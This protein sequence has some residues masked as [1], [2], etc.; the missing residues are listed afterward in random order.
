MDL[1]ITLIIIIITALVSLGGFSTPRIIDDLIFYPARMK[2]GRELHRYI[3]HGFI[4]ADLV[5]LFFNMFTFY[6]FGQ[7]IEFKFHE[8]TGHKYVFPIFYLTALIV[9]SIPDYLNHRNDYYYRSLGASGAVNAILFSFVLL[10]PW[11]II[12]VLVIPIP[13]FIY[14]VLFV[15]YSIYAERKGGDRV[16]HSAH[17]FGAAYGVAFTL[18]LRPEVFRDFIDQLIHPSFST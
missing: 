17:L 9:A 12:Q 10:A 14:A 13:A 3:T 18:A 11:D 1:S 8:W 7:L 4:H 2:G 15:I 6:F 5:H 16:N